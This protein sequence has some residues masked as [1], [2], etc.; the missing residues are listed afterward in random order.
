MKEGHVV[1]AASIFPGL[2][3]RS[4]SRDLIS[5][6]SGWVGAENMDICI[7][8]ATKTAWNRQHTPCIYSGLETD[9]VSYLR[10]VNLLFILRS[11]PGQV[12]YEELRLR[13]EL[14]ASAGS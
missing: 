14:I 6:E 1:P 5:E 12:A 9:T 7:F 11:A 2:R 4:V 10:K 3:G 13:P 8:A